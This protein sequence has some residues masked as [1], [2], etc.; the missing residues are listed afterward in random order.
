[1]KNETVQFFNNLSGSAATQAS[2]P[3]SHEHGGA[4]HSHDFGL[5]EHGHTHEHLEHAGMLHTFCILVRWTNRLHLS[6]ENT[7]SVTCRTFRP[8]TL[9]SA[10]LQS[11]LEG[12]CTYVWKGG[13]FIDKDAHISSP[14]GSGKTA[15]TLALCQ[16]LRKEFN[17]GECTVHSSHILEA[18]H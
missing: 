4:A 13:H 15:L 1:M 5:G 11:E 12:N 14:V 3:H 10:D 17:I 8:A 9:R 7:Q 18:G 16:R 2:A 6:K